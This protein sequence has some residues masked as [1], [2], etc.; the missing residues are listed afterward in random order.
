MGYTPK[1][2]EEI[3]NVKPIGVRYI[4]EFCHNGEMIASNS[5]PII[6]TD[7][8]PHMRKHY[9]NICGAQMMLP[10]TYPYIEWVEDKKE[11]KEDTK[12][13]NTDGAD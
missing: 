4:C 2:H 12:G 9:C 13:D 3:F 5:D 11:E 6:L 7:G 1:N 8:I 10:K